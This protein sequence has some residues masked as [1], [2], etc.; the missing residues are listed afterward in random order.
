MFKK[1]KWKSRYLINI[2]Y[3]FWL[4]LIKYIS[5]NREKYEDSEYV[6]YVIIIP[7]V[8]ISSV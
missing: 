5:S 6:H 3:N 4:T 7:R 8:L 1:Y 2:L